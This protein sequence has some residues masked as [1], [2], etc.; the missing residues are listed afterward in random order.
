MLTRWYNAPG[1]FS[2]MSRL[3]K[4]MDRFFGESGSVS[5]AGVFPSFNLYDDGDNL[6]LRAEI[7]GINPEKLNINATVNSLTVKGERDVPLVDEKASFHRQERGYGKFSRTISLP[8]AIA[9]DK[10]KADYKLGILT[11]TL[12]KA[13]EAKPRKIEISA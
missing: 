8:Q 9:T 12:P 4:E 11:I 6:M 10:V 5:T 13:E 7:P 2:E 3:S 1:I